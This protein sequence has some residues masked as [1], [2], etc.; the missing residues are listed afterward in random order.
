[1]VYLAELNMNKD[2]KFFCLDEFY[3][4]HIEPNADEAGLA[5]LNC[6]NLIETRAFLSNEGEFMPR[7]ALI[8]FPGSGSSW[9]RLG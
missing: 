3:E 1:M 4:Y 2:F 8:S 6:S 7:T 5:S 9:I